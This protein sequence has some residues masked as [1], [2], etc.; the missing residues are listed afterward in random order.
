MEDLLCLSSYFPPTPVLMIPGAVSEE[1][2]AAAGPEAQIKPHL[3]RSQNWQSL[4]GN[5]AGDLGTPAW[6]SFNPYPPQ[7]EYVWLP[8][9]ET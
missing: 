2:G 3:S 8:S 4:A 5:E 7:P 1:T 6:Q 9:K